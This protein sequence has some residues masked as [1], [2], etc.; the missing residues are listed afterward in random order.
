MTISANYPTIR[1]SLLLDFANEQVLDPR[2]TFTRASTA[3]YYDG[4]TTALAEQ[5]LLTYS[6]DFSNGVWTK[7]NSTVTVNSTTAPDGTTTATTLLA[8]AGTSISPIIFI[9]PIFTNPAIYSVY[10]KAG[11]NNY[12]QIC[13]NNASAYV[14]FDLSLG[15]VGTSVGYTG[16]IVSVGNGWYR[17]SAYGTLYSTMRFYIAQSASSGASTAYNPVGTESVYLWGAQLEQRS[18]VTAYTPTTTAAI[19]NYIPALQTAA[20]GVARFDHNPTTGES[21]GLLIEQQSTNLVLQSEDF[22]TTWATTNSSVGSN[23]V[24]SPL[25]TL[26]ADKLIDTSANTTHIVSQNVTTTAV[27]ITL[28]LYLKAAGKTFAYLGI[29]DSTNTQRLTYFNLTTG[30]VATIGTGITPSITPV[31]NGWYRCIVTVATAYAGV[32]PITIGCATADNTPTYIGNGVDGIAMFGAQLEANSFATSYIPTVASQVT[33]IADVASMTGTNFSSWYNIS[34]GTIYSRFAIQALQATGN[35]FN[36]NDGTTGNYIRV[37]NNLGTISSQMVTNT[38]NNVNISC[39]TL[40]PTG[41]YTAIASAYKT[42][43]YYEST[44]GNT[45]VADTSNVVPTVNQ[46][47][48]GIALTANS[49][50]STI[51][52]LAYYPKRLT[53]AQLQA[54]TGS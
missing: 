33:R 22:T 5:N 18:A 23:Q 50:N 28:S 19:T 44:N 24:I 15:V 36:I 11:T 25:G 38:V 16:A 27:A 52:K 39:I 37:I 47:Q 8:N 35:A 53:N 31:G 54:L 4:Q 51:S 45:G 12:I 20:S 34:E 3:T 6:Q 29:N 42:N 7:L 40:V 30:T 1:P 32:N 17:C 43:D 9:T 41:T 26:V 13:A 49:L 46:F 2:I 21:L 48:I 10:A 14:N